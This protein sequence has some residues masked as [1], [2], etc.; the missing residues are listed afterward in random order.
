[1]V[2]HM[3]IPM[4]LVFIIVAVPSYMASNSNSYYYGSSKIYGEDTQYGQDTAAIEETF[5][6]N[7]TYVLMVPN[8]DTEAEQSLSDALHE[9]PEITSIL[10][11]V[12]TVGAEIPQGISGC[13]YAFAARIR[14]V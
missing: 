8:G 2:S 11:Y 6:K 13:R 12:D 5:G 3:M 14:Q 10:S 7:D 4:A 1:M 9:I